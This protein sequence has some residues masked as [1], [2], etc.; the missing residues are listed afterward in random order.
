MNCGP[1]GYFLGFAYPICSRYYEYYS[2]F[3]NDAQIFINCTRQK[4]IDFLLPYYNSYPND[5]NCSSIM[6]LAFSSHYPVYQECGFCEIVWK[7][8]G[9]FCTIFTVIGKEEEANYLYNM[10]KQCLFGHTNGANFP[11]VPLSS[12]L[13]CDTCQN[14]FNNLQKLAPRQQSDASVTCDQSCVV[15]PDCWFTTS[16]D[17]LVSIVQTFTNNDSI[18]ACQQI[19]L[20]S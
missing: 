17:P 9:A 20:C 13:L 11:T 10:A 2:L 8:L 6:T 15:F 3:T 19:G 5:E 4:L 12:A 7:N 18:S 14:I 1:N 16:N